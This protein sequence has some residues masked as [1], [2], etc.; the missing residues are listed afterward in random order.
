MIKQFEDFKLESEP[1]NRTFVAEQL[2]NNI[3]YAN[4]LGPRGLLGTSGS[5]GVTGVSGILGNSGSSYNQGYS[6]FQEKKLPILEVELNDT[7]PIKNNL[8]DYFP[9]MHFLNE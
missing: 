6:T 2:D 5:Q 1:E 9:T 3:A 7:K 8:E 4:F